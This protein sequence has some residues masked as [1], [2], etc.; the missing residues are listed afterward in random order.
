MPQ[1]PQNL[2]VALQLKPQPPQR[3][4]NGPPQ[5]SQNRWVSGFAV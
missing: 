5:A 1:P 2:A 3:N 4:G